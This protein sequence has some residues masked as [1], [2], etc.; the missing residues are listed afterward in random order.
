MYRVRQ[1][2]RVVGGEVL[3][4]RVAVV[5]DEEHSVRRCYPL[6]V[7][8]VDGDASC[9]YVREQIVGEI[10][11]V[12]ARHLV[13]CHP[14]ATILHVVRRHIQ[15]PRRCRQ[16]NIFVLVLRYMKQ[17]V[18]LQRSVVLVCECWSACVVQLV[19]LVVVGKEF[20]L[21]PVAVHE[22]HVAVCR[23]QKQL[24][25]IP[26]IVLRQSDVVHHAPLAVLAEHFQRICNLTVQHPQIARRVVLHAGCHDIVLALVGCSRLERTIVAVVAL[27]ELAVLKFVQTALGTHHHVTLL[28]RVEVHA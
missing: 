20:R 26:S 21:L 12:V 7:A 23:T 1:Q 16:P 27:H 6:A 3:D 9:L 15:R 8:A 17:I 13:L 22:P 28:Q 14:T 19:V 10:R 4:L 18:W 24:L 11:S 5:A 25:H 2:W